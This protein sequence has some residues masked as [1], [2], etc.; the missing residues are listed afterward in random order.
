MAISYYFQP[1]GF[2]AETYDEA[3]KQLEAAGAASPKGRSLHVGLEINGQ[4]AV[5]DIWDSQE[6]FEAFGAT[7]LPIMSALGAEPG[8]PMVAPV[9]NVIQG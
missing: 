9:H 5:F 2:S 6:D 4:I 3:I 1:T 7:L 8:E